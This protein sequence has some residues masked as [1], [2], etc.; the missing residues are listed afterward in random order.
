M[1]FTPGARSAMCFERG[2]I[3]QSGR[4]VALCVV[5]IALAGCE[6]A[7]G[8]EVME[9]EVE[10]WARAL[11]RGDLGTMA[12]RYES[13]GVFLPPGDHAVV[14]REA[15][16]THWRNIHDRFLVT[17]DYEVDSIWDDGRIGHLR[18]SYRVSG[19][20]RTAGE[21]FRAED[22]FMQIWRRQRDGGWLI[23][24]DMWSPPADSDALLP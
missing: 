17:F 7:T 3:R 2:A 18:G 6:L 8:A 14:G 11:E 22:E 9:R 5:L 10:S 16:S 19:V 21:S 20:A 15:V 12:A 4:L 23:A 1:R 24:L 13:G